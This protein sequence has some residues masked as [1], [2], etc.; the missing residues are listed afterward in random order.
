MNYRV[1]GEQP[2]NF[3]RQYEPTYSRSFHTPLASHVGI[4]TA[5]KTFITLRKANNPDGAPVGWAILR[6]N[7]NRENDRFFNNL[8]AKYR[9]ILPDYE[10]GA[11]GVY[12]SAIQ[13]LDNSETRFIDKFT[14]S[15]SSPTTLNG[16]PSA[17]QGVGYFLSEV[18]NN[19][20]SLIGHLN[21]GF[22][23][24][25]A[26]PT[27]TILLIKYM[28]PELA[29]RHKLKGVESAFVGMQFGV[30]EAVPGLSVEKQ[31]TSVNHT[32]VFL[33]AFKDAT[34]NRW[35]AYKQA[36]V[37]QNGR[38]Y[39]PMTILLGNLAVTF[40]IAVFENF[41]VIIPPEEIRRTGTRITTQELRQ[42]WTR[43][44]DYGNTLVRSIFRA[45]T[46]DKTFNELVV[47]LSNHM[48]GEYARLDPVCD[49]MSEQ[50]VTNSNLL[51]KFTRCYT[52]LGAV[53][54]DR[55]FTARVATGSYQNNMGM[56]GYIGLL[57]PREHGP[58][59]SR[60]FN[61]PGNCTVTALI[62][63]D[64]LR[65][66]ELYGYRFRVFGKNI[67]NNITQR[68]AALPTI[69]PAT[70]EPRPGG[71]LGDGTGEAWACHYGWEPVPQIAIPESTR[72]RSGNFNYY[73]IQGR[74]VGEY[75]PRKSQFND[76]ASIYDTITLNAFVR[77]IGRAEVGL[78]PRS[79][80]A[81]ILTLL[82]NEFLPRVGSN[83]TRRMVQYG[84]VDTSSA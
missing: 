56:Y 7:K 66:K 31:R 49:Q 70:Y 28:N 80:T 45:D 21:A 23:I 35:E 52:S 12:I 18:N 26:L 79:R 74:R 38:K 54:S 4:D 6:K 63:A 59:D 50:H 75:Y 48:S 73:N 67:Y 47:L 34:M 11:W 84:A 22:V 1:Q 33:T 68:L 25:G 30:V 60:L 53:A 65:F 61:W 29:Q 83:R 16:R 36:Y 43:S 40:A 72:M 69:D 44:A 41:G 76:R 57:Q 13:R 17:S 24:H 77:A 9:T 14:R 78:Q 20:P 58:T 55:S 71:H 51:D 3:R 46:Y 32:S 37:G 5:L 42:L 8:A 39:L 64:I 2:N 81:E 27:G 19:M 10:P 62:M 15:Y 82:R